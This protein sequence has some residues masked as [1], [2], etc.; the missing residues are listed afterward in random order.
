MAREL[1]R[2]DLGQ[3]S[4]GTVEGS[5]PGP[6]G[7]GPESVRLGVQSVNIDDGTRCGLMVGERKEFL[8][9]A[10]FTATCS[11]RMT[12][13]GRDDH[14]T[15]GLVPSRKVHAGWDMLLSPGVDDGFSFLLCFVHC[16][17]GQFEGAIDS[18]IQPQASPAE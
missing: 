3:M 8:N 14:L 2:E 6:S 18:S 1:H 12:H 13:S 17:V 5:P 11:T 10:R 9:S 16:V 7:L 15:T 4:G